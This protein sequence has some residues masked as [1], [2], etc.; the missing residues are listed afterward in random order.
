MQ[1]PTGVTV[2]AVL[3]FIG[4]ALCA[5]LALLAFAGGSMISSILSQAG[6]STGGG[7]AGG[8]VAIV[9]VVILAIAALVI[10]TGI[11]LI[12][13]KG[14]GRIIQ[15]V[16]AAL[17]VLGQIKS[18]TGGLSG[19]QYTLPVIILAYDVWVIWYLLTPGVKAAFA[20]QPPAAA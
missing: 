4:G 1:R 5:L 19:A 17:G 2:I 16:L 11:G 8:L 10:I 15:I 14:W 12:K 20:G 7:I 9:G 3:D 13:L 6:A 18:F